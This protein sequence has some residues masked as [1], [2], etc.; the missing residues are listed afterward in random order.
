MKIYVRTRGP[1]QEQGYFWREKDQAQGDF[2]REKEPMFINDYKIHDLIEP[3]EFCL[4][5]CREHDTSNLLLLITGLESKR[6]SPRGDK[7]SNS[8]AWVWENND[9]DN[10]LRNLAVQALEDK[11]AET[12]DKAITEE[13]N[14]EYGFTIN[15]DKIKPDE[16]T[17][18]ELAI[19]NEPNEC[20]KSNIEHKNDESKKKLAEELK[21]RKLPKKDGLLVVV[22]G[23]TP[24]KKLKEAGVWRGLSKLVETDEEYQLQREIGIKFFLGSL[25]IILIVALLVIMLHKQPTTKPQTPQT[26]QPTPQTIIQPTQ[27]QVYR[28]LIFQK[29]AALRIQP[30]HPPEINP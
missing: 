14:G 21:Q 24:A 30:N 27:E 23:F 25:A 10:E 29:N 7:I 20:I 16:L 17:D 9:N 19:E 8:V 5:I 11:L 13:K 28:N 18:V 15:G 3:E 6:E 26:P 4:V 1:Y 22:T 12:I 2:W